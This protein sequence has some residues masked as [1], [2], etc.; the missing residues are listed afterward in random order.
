MKRLLLAATVAATTVGA[1]PTYTQGK[2]TWSFQRVGTF[3][4]HQNATLGDVTVAEIIAASADGKT[5]VYTDAEQ[6]VVGF[7]DITDPSRPEAAGTVALDPNPTDDVEYS[8]TS[9]DVLR[10]QYALVSADTSASKKRPSGELVVIDLAAG[11]IVAR[12]DLGGQPDSLK[13]SPDHRFV[14]IAIENERDENVC[15]GGSQNDRQVV[16]SSLGAG[17]TTAALCTAGGGAVGVMPQNQIGNP[18]GYLAVIRTAGAPAS[19]VRQDVALTGVADLFP[20]DPEPEFV[21]INEKNQAVVTLQENNHIVIVDLPSL[22]V[23]GDFPAGTVDLTQ[24]DTVRAG[25]GVP[26]TIALVNSAARVRREP[27]GVAWLGERVA[28]ANEGDLVQNLP[29]TSAQGGGRGFTIFNLD[30]SVAFDSGNSF[31][32]LAVRF[33]HYPERRSNSKGTEPEAI[34]AAKYGPDDLLFVGSERGS[35]VAVYQLDRA[36]QPAF[37]QLLPAPLGPEG[38]LTI[39]HRNLLVTSG[40][41]DTPPYGVRSTVQIYE[42]RRGEPTYPQIYSMNGP[43]GT[44]IPWSALSGM[45]DVPGRPGTVQAVWDSFFTPSQVFTIDVNQTPAVITGALA[46]QRPAASPFYDPEGLAY[47]PDGSLWVAS[48]GNADDSRPNRLI[49][50][51]PT[52]GAVLAEV[53]LPPAVLACRAAEPSGSPARGSY[54]SGFEGLDIAPRPGGGYLISVAQQRGWNFTTSPACDALDDDATDTGAAEP[55][56]TRIWVYDPQIPSWSHV[57][58]QLAPKPANAAWIGLSEITHTESGWI[59]IERDNLTGDFGVYKTLVRIPLSPGADGAFTSDE[60][61]VFDLRPSLTATNGWI[62]DKPEGVAVLQ[63]GR[64]FLVTDN[65]GVDGWSGE[66]WFLS[67]GPHWHLFH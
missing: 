13:V 23:V 49:K 22:A 6:G 25:S 16:G 30:G 28:T 55:T 47:A 15:V 37:A 66:T 57:P 26:N 46:I 59:V 54:G 53:G 24:I 32:H 5:L 50:V 14:A 39:P 58:Y 17:Q 64:L 42:L 18:A 34:A 35:L 31:E 20:D 67:L 44:P 43:A 10:N 60:K 40:E 12:L 38:L 21:D 56:W 52:T 63:D 36:G 19:W 61:S 33:G 1:Q 3:A 41:N 29:P 2:G 62:T 11:A 4:N 65:D 51:D 8:P 7:I 48:E 45:T 9:V 27:D